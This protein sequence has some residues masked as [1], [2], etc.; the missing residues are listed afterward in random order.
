MKRVSEFQMMRVETEDGRLLGHVFDLRSRGEPEHGETRDE[1]VVNELVYGKLGLLARLGITQ[2]RATT[3]A[4]ESVK[5]IRDGKI[6][7][8]EASTEGKSE[9]AKGKREDG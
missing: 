4:W 1:R 9:K 7:V 5:E 6:I 2:A 3:V 8:D